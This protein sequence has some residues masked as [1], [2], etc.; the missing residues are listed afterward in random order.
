MAGCWLLTAGA[1]L[2]GLIANV[3]SFDCWLFWAEGMSEGITDWLILISPDPELGRCSTVRN[4]QLKLRF[5]PTPWL[6]SNCLL[7]NFGWGF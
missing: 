1:I 3:Y 2:E 5:P 6:Y 4:P 7:G